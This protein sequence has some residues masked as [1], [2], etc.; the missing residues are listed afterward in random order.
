MTGAGCAN[1]SFHSRRPRTL[2][3]IIYGRMTDDFR[4]GR[5]ASTDTV[6]PAS[7]S[8]GT[9]QHHSI[10]PESALIQINTPPLLPDYPLGPV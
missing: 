10:S 7:L 1:V 5:V 2:T 4:S 3:S 9:P 6:L 8:F